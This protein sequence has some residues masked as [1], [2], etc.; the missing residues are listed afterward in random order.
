[1]DSRLGIYS[2]E[3][4]FVDDGSVTVNG[5]KLGDLGWYLTAPP[6][7][8]AASFRTSYTTVSG[9]HGSRDMT[10]EDDAGLSFAE[11][12]SVTLALRTVGTYVEAS[13]SKIALGGLVGREAEIR[14]RTLPGAFRGRLSASEPSETWVDGVFSHCELTL[15]LEAQPLLFGEEVTAS[16]KELTVQGN[17]GAYPTIEGTATVATARVTSPDHAFIE[18]TGLKSGA[19]VRI[20][21]DDSPARGA[22]VNG[23]RVLPTI[24]SDFFRLQPGK[25]V[26]DVVGLN[27]SKIS[28]EPLW[29]IP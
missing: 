24:D 16:S 21:C 8:D 1:M 15:T 14:W 3:K 2:R 9:A 19:A 4:M 23:N 22:F 26:L 5:I 20:V 7:V 29:L 11:R 12:R 18:V 28:Y 13:E 17:V 27:I 6:S 10:L 25:N